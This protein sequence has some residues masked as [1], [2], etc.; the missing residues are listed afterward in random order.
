MRENSPPPKFDPKI[1]PS[2]LDLEKWIAKI[3]I[4][5]LKKTGPLNLPLYEGEIT[6]EIEKKIS[7]GTNLTP[8]ECMGIYNQQ[9]WFRFFTLAQE[10]FPTLVRLFGY[11]DF[12]KLITE[13]A[14][15]KY[16]ATHWGIS[17]AAAQIPRWIKE[18]YKEEDREFIFQIAQIDAIHHQL[19]YAPSLSDQELTQTKAL[20]PFVSCLELNG[21]LLD[22]RE[23][24]LK[25]T[26]ENWN[27]RPFPEIDFSRTYFI[28]FCQTEINLIVEEISEIE[29]RYFKLFEKNNSSQI[30]REWLEKWIKKNWIG[31]SLNP[32]K[33]EACLFL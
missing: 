12:N 28:S 10:N 33:E 32:P 2:L 3:I 26:V 20:Q 9:Y 4:Q 25:E 15:L 1:P 7:P 14:I 27:D 23:K 5:P 19:F 16:P 24:L 11:A 8:E 29:F 13:P 17:S 21:N 6:A 18:E 31:S 22:F 30:P